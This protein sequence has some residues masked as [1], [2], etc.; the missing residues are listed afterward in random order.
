MFDGC[1]V[2]SSLESSLVG[3]SCH[4]KPC[5]P[6]PNPSSNASRSPKHVHLCLVSRRKDSPTSRGLLVPLATLRSGTARHTFSTNDHLR[7]MYRPHRLLAWGDSWA[8][9]PQKQKSKKKLFKRKSP[10]TDPNAQSLPHGSAIPEQG[11]PLTR[12]YSVAF[13]LS[14]IFS[15]ALRS[16][17]NR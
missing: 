16:A 12:C 17:E 14:P 4:K 9:S 1:K 2:H 7:T 8:P 10:K 5:Q 3:C 15:E 11:P 6:T 13:S